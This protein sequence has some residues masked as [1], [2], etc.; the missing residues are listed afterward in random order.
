MNEWIEELSDLTAAGEPV[1]L[2][3]VARIRGSAPREAG[4]RMLVTGSESIG[5]IGGGQLE[6]QCA[7]IAAG[8]LAGDETPVLRN[9]P[10][11]PALGQ[12]CGGVVDVLFEPIASGLPD[13]LRDLRAVYGQRQPAVLVTGTR[14]VGSFVVTGE[15]VY[16][17]DG[18]DVPGA[19]IE[20]ARSVLDA[21]QTQLDDSLLYA[22]V[23][24]NDFDIAV[25]GAGHVGAAVVRALSAL[26]C[27]IRWIDS[28][29]NIF[30]R[31]PANVR[32]VEAEAPALE[33]AAMPPSSCYLV[34]THSH[35]LD[36]EICE[37]ILRRGDAAYCGLIGSLTKRRRFEKR[38][39]QQGLPASSIDS[40]VCPI[41]V[42]GISGKKPAEI[43]IAA[44]A[45]LLRAY[46]LSRS[47]SRDL[48]G[49]VHP[50]RG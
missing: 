20:R 35:P 21:K 13:W 7:H 6:H 16:A 19:A 32:A 12:C 30:R 40:L 18:P 43:A 15:A 17:P 3:T 22:A 26:D 36:F 2:V 4:A 11:G 23:V 5:T 31:T 8:L 14:D 46:E 27:N 39:R 24:G 44:A 48:P 33:V 45:D 41:G 38:F 37:R 50:I 47:G 29:R 10:L 34:M 28:R 1:V 9:F 42:E 25:F 49:N